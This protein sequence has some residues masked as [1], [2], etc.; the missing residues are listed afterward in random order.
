MRRRAAPRVT[1]SNP[2]RS[3]ATIAGPLAVKI[4]LTGSGSP[5]Q[6]ASPRTLAQQDLADGGRFGR[7]RGEDPLVERGEPPHE[8]R[9]E[10]QP[11]ALEQR[12]RAHALRVAQGEVDRDLPALAPPDHDAGA[13]PSAS[14]SA[15]ASSACRCTF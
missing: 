6:P 9:A 13:A 7:G 1:S 15:A 8:R 12:Q 5:S 4:S 3:S 14:I 2:P 10:R 11:A